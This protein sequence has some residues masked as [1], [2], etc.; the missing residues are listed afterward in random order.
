M[1]LRTIAK[2]MT[3]CAAVWVALP[4][5]T[6]DAQGCYTPSCP[7]AVFGG[8][9]S[10]GDGSS[11]PVQCVGVNL[12]SDTNHCT[13]GLADRVN[14]VT[15]GWAQPG[16]TNNFVFQG[17]E[18]NWYYPSGWVG[19][20]SCKNEDSNPTCAECTG[21]FAI[22]LYAMYGN[23][24]GT[25]TL[26]PEALP[27]A[28]RAVT[29][30]RGE[31]GSSA[32]NATVSANGLYNF[33]SQFPP[34]RRDN[35]W[36]VGL[37]ARPF[38][39]SA[40][41]EKFTLTC[42]TCAEGTRSATSSSTLAPVDVTCRSSWMEDP[43]IQ[44]PPPQP[45]GPNPPCGAEGEPV[46]VTT[47]NVFLDQTDAVAP[48]VAAH[49]L[50]FRRTY[51]SVNTAS[52]RYGVFGPGWFH[53][54][55]K[56]LSEPAA[57]VLLLRDSNGVPAYFQDSDANGA[58]ETSVPFTQD[59]SI[60][61][62]ADGTFVRQFRS[63]G[64][65]RYAALP[66]GRL[67]AVVDVSGNTTT[68]QYTG[69]QLTTI[70]DPGSRQFTLAYPNASTITL[71][72]PAGLIA[73]FTLQ[74]GLLSAVTY[75]DGDGDGQSD[76]GFTFTY[77][78]TAPKRLLSITDASGRLVEAHTYTPAGQG[79]T[80][81]LGGGVEK[82][83]FSYQP[84]KTVV[85]DARNKVTTYEYSM[86]WGQKLV[87]RITG[88][89]SGCGGG[90][91]QEWTYDNR[92]RIT[93]HRDGEGNVTT[94]TY[95]P[96]T[97]DVLSENRAAQAGGAVTHTTSYTY[98]P[99]RR[100]HTRTKPNGGVTTFAYGPA[101]PTS[102]TEQVTASENRTTLIQYTVQ[103]K[104]R[105]VTDPRSK[106]W[107]FSYNTLGDLEWVKD[108]TPAHNQTSY[109]YDLMGRLRQVVRP[110]VTGDPP[111]QEP[112]TTYDVLGR[113]KRI[114]NPDATFWEVTYDGGGRRTR[115]RDPLGRF[116]DHVYDTY[117]R[118]DIV[119]DALLGETDYGYDLASNLT[120]ITDARE[121]TTVFDIDD[122]NRVRKVCYHPGSPCTKFDEYTYDAAGRM[123]T[124]KD[125]RNVTTTYSYDGLG[126]LTGK[127]YSDSTPA[128]TFAYDQG[129]PGQKGSMTTAASAPVTLT[130]SYD[131]AG[132]MRTATTARTGSPAHTVAYTYDAAG[133][134]ASLTLDG[135]LFAN[136]TWED[137]NLLQSIL[138]L[139]NRT[140]SFGYDA[141]GRR[142]TLAFANGVVTTY[143]YDNRS[144]LSSISAVAGGN[145]IVDL[146]YPL[147][148]P[149]DNRLGRG[150]S[151]APPESYEYDELYRL[152]TV[153]R[154]AQ[155]A[156][157]YSYD[158][159]GNRL[160][161]LPVPVW[162]YDDWN[163]LTSN[164]AATLTYD[165]DGNLTQKV[166]GGGVWTY[167][168]DAE[169]RLTRTRKDNADVASYV[170]DALGRRMERNVV[171]GA[172][173]HSYIHD[174]EDI[175]R[176]GA[177][178]ATDLV[179]ELYLHGPGLDEPLE[180]LDGAATVSSYHA[181]A[182]GSIVR[183]TND[184]GGAALARQHDAFGSP[185]LGA[186]S[187][188]YA[189]TGREWDQEAALYYYRAR[190]YDPKIGRFLS[191]DPVG[192]VEGLNLYSYVDNDPINWI[193]PSGEAKGGKQNI[194]VTHGG[195]TLTKRTPLSEIE[196]CLKEA[197]EKAMNP[198]HIK[199]LTG[200]AKVVRRGGAMALASPYI[201][202]TTM[203]EIDRAKRCG[204]PSCVQEQHCKDLEEEGNPDFVL[205]P[206]GIVPNP[207]KCGGP[208]GRSCIY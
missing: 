167:D 92:G 182:I 204:G 62:Q 25:A 116:T 12:C 173:I 146:T 130:W 43:S 87:T 132:Q 71:S 208:F 174:N 73:T 195:K 38:A 193:D 122:H 191:E 32:G 155:T 153:T 170:Y 96:V 11:I 29:A 24:A 117:G 163:R 102:I 139:P 18:G 194:S 95:D 33:A 72:G 150:G 156:E 124:R 47:G 136:Y 141:A 176:V 104:P 6:V 120:S 131:L 52:G 112:E 83:T 162:N 115:V 54:Y 108:P 105:F 97:G 121:K 59:S 149:L 103:G 135:Q 160:S 16:A 40:V 91:S 15:Q 30:L 199:K 77:Q 101:G 180:S 159:V 63:G 142:K 9:V 45:N 125:R 134:R 157:D 100:T 7:T 138:R 42:G 184:I 119:R 81:E 78:T 99:D 23:F 144:R 21:S 61:R 53:N 109:V 201:V 113:V 26:L 84:L 75:A 93:S 57:R 31:C 107:E 22:V 145:T 179:R 172:G 183:T 90:E 76:G 126:R 148:D 79:L 1:S 17:T 58:Y 44:P 152:S 19:T 166:E 88:P 35:N 74:T 164:S 2:L 207:C 185:E 154:G 192:Y 86:V 128:A 68:L 20:G 205:S 64:S 187:A 181:D 55:E 67:T 140:Y 89:C 98:Y 69:S 46:S 161:S 175:L 50:L 80:S 206:V 168:W 8:S 178:S 60:T 169:N 197:I 65:E 66:S 114:T 36:G 85:T 5:D 49:G 177:G 3:A 186:A 51:N 202:D 13:G 56:R 27:A 171:G 28:G 200:L 143:G 147:Y 34:P 106:V 188:G 111:I 137:R 10:A 151:T 198:R 48:G 94:Y 190:Y 4:P 118:L 133:N 127:T 70:T 129:G 41:T 123:E 158:A 203:A 189:Y 110:A 165:D 37:G 39:A 82:F 196:A 14:P